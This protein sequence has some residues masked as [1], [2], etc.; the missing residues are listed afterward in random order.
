MKNLTLFLIG[1]RGAGK[2]TVGQELAENLRLP[3]YSLD[4][5]I[6]SKAEKTI[7]E[8]VG[9]KG[10]PYFRDLESAALKE[11]SSKKG[12]VDCGGGI[13]EREENRILLKNQDWVFFLKVSVEE[14]QNRLKD[15]TDRP[16]LTGKQD[17]LAEIASVY[18]RR[19]PLYEEAARYILDANKNSL[20]TAGEILEIL[21][22]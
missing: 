16:S 3:L 10:W 11:Y 8:I 18:S 17:Y 7:T 2:S 22:K 9:E 20:D 6:E 5:V 12:I 1:Y 13:I 14:A 21:K 19:M 15:K 4:R